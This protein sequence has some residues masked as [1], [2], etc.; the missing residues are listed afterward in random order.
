MDR[1]RL[2]VVIAALISVPLLLGSFGG[3][4]GVGPAEAAPDVI[5]RWWYQM[6]GSINWSTH[7]CEGQF[8]A[9]SN[10]R[11]VTWGDEPTGWAWGYFSGLD[12]SI[13][14]HGYIEVLSDEWTGNPANQGR[15]QIERSDGEGY[16]DV[17]PQS[18]LYGWQTLDYGTFS[19]VTEMDLG[20]RSRCVEDQ[21]YRDRGDKCGPEVWN[22]GCSC[23]PQSD[24]WVQRV[25]LTYTTPTCGNWGPTIP[26]PACVQ[27]N[28]LEGHYY[29][30]AFDE[31]LKMVRNDP[32]ISFW[33][34]AYSPDMTKLECDY[35]STIWTGYVNLPEPGTWTF[36][37]WGDDWTQVY[38]ETAPGNWELVVYDWWTSHTPWV[39]KSGSV[40]LDAGWYGIAVYYYEITGW[41][42][43]Y[44]SYSGPG[45][46]LQLIP[47]SR[48]RSCYPPVVAGP[49][50]T[51]TFTEISSGALVGSGTAGDPYKIQR[52]T[53]WIKI[54]TT[55]TPD[56]GGGTMNFLVDGGTIASGIP[57]EAGGVWRLTWDGSSTL[58]EGPHNVN[59]HFNGFGSW[60][61]SDGYCYFDIVAPANAEYIISARGEI[62]NLTKSFCWGQ[63]SGCLLPYYPEGNISG[64]NTPITAPTYDELLDRFGGDASTW[65]N[66]G[67]FPNTTGVWRRYGN[68]TRN[69]TFN[70]GNNRKIVLFVDGTLTIGGAVDVPSSSAVV[71]IAKKIRF[72]KNLSG[73][74]IVGGLYIAEGDIET[75]YNYAGTEVTPRLIVYGSLI[76]TKGTI[77]LKRKLS[78]ADNAKYAAE[79][80]RLDPKYYY[81]IAQYL[82]EAQV[83]WK[84]V[85]P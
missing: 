10:G 74:D 54:K 52:G 5:E 69:S 20:V 24:V 36:Y 58:V 63:G 73:S 82:G 23:G 15:I 46:D 9:D 39:L 55:A 35:F 13:T 80:I 84:E 67:S 70:F 47:S 68:I 37:T 53:E 38:L 2:L 56:P 14:Y 40:T 18:S 42:F 41:A 66:G 60:G 6:E 34:D 78:D 29:R 57:R 43:D 17:R 48:L 85:A 21:C 71:F 77:I 12:P 76:S 11:L 19:G 65:S 64:L 1:K 72:S 33:W 16:Q 50:L 30:G 61:T 62:S 79:Q 49:E 59:A 28:A 75:A 22:G 8:Y 45:T 32:T 26:E 81:L 25:Y 31:G 7:S 51:C 4:V 83:S 3:E 27:A 44:V